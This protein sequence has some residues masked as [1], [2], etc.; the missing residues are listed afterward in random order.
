MEVRK[1]SVC[2]RLASERATFGQAR[3]TACGLRE[4]LSARATDNDG[5]GVRENSGDGEAARA[6]DIHEERVGVL[7]KSLELVLLSLVLR[8]WVE[9]VDGESLKKGKKA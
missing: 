5:L 4:D 6:L 3:L 9:K 1:R 8:S 2:L 7:H